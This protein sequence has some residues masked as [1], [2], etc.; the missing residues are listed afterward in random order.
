[1]PK[2]RIT[3]IGCGFT[4]S[5]VGLALRRQFKDAEIIGHDKDQAAARR[6]EKL[7]AIDKG[8]WNLPNACEGAAM[9]ILAIPADGIESTLKVIGRDLPAGSIVM[10]LSGSATA[11]LA[12]AAR[13]VPREVTFAA[14][15]IVFHPDRVPVGTPVESAATDMIENA[16]WTLTPQSGTTP[17]A[18]DGLA[19]LIT[20]F[21]AAPVFM[22]A[23]EQD[24]LRLSVQMLPGLL[25][26]ALVNAVASDGAWRERQ[27]LAGADFGQATERVGEAK[28]IALAALAQPQATVHWLNQVMLQLM[29]VRD[30]ISDGSTEELNAL[31]AQSI[32][33]REA[34]LAAWRKGREDGRVAQAKAPTLL[35]AFVGQNIAERLQNK[36]ASKNKL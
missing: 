24:G 1:M 31:L 30:A 15:T 2:T 7:G 17:D 28:S 25:G 18:S 13:H 20:S 21:G 22:D 8:D 26:A 36:P 11:A 5:V 32:E 33:R 14:S 29:A 23:A 3:V 12:F 27:W 6:A 9:V 34:W 10:T 19:G 4:G 35:S 16:V